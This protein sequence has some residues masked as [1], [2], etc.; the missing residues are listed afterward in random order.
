MRHLSVVRWFTPCFDMQEGLSAEEAAER[1]ADTMRASVRAHAI[2]DV[3]AGSFL[4]A[5]V[6][7]LLVAYEANELM[8][9]RTFSVGRAEQ[10]YSELDAAATFASI[11]GIQNGG[12][13]ISVEEFFSAVPDVQYAMDEPL[14]SPSAV[15]LWFLA[16]FAAEQ[17]KVVMSGEGADELF[18]GYPLYQEALAYEP[19]MKVPAALRR[20]AGAVACELP[21]FHGRRFL[22]RGAHGLEGRFARGV[23][24]RSP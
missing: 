12:R 6:D 22:M 23:R 21:P 17:V 1:I 8:D 24:V 15:P 4:S 16:H 14:S 7:S 5:G 19:Y 20:A 13:T 10:K 18:G 2:A 3:E 9:L 11:A